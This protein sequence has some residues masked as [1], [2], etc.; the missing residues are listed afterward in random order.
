MDVAIACDDGDAAALVVLVEVQLEVDVAKQWSWPPYQAAAGARYK[1]DACVLVMALDERVAAWAT[2][3]VSLGPGG[4][5]FRAVVLGPSS[6]PRVASDDEAKRG[7]ELALLSALCHG[8]QSPSRS[9]SRSHRLRASVGSGR[10]RTSICRDIISVR[11]SIERWRRSWRRASKHK[12][13]SDFARKYY[14]KGRP[15]ERRLGYVLPS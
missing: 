7:P 15:R 9:G 4:S 5:V 11:R 6:V 3:P 10:R 12:Y 1:C 13:L 14:G 8:E 2:A